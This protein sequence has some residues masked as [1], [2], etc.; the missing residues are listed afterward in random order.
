MRWL[1]GVATFLA[2][3]I[4]SVAGAVPSDG[5][6]DTPRSKCVAK[7]EHVLASDRQ[8]VV[9]ESPG[10]EWGPHLEDES[11]PAIWACAYG[12]ML[13]R[14]GAPP[15]AGGSKYGWTAVSHVVLSGATVAYEWESFAGTQAEAGPQFDLWFVVV[16]D[17][18]SDRLL[19]R[20]PTGDLLQ[21][22]HGSAG[23]GAVESMVLEPSGSVAWIATDNERSSQLPEQFVCKPFETCGYRDRPQYFDLYASDS[24]GTRLLASGTK[25]AP[26]SLTL[27]GHTM[28]WTQA[29]KRMS[30]ALG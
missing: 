11:G 1:S 7:H 12:H 24:S 27:A 21:P 14:I 3:G 20:V 23:V 2:L 26:S 5:A 30:A 17:I 15:P 19:R 28:H 9:F 18:R 10:G 8:A 6:A 22:E 13:Y 16:R 29:G 4:V 25:I